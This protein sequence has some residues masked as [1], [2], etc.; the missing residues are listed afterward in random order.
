MV[1]SYYHLCGLDSYYRLFIS[2]LFAF[3]V[4][5][6]AIGKDA[7]MDNDVYIM[8]NIIDFHKNFEIAYVD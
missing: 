1:D 7:D 5:K 6:Q 2:Q 4:A 8:K 3:E